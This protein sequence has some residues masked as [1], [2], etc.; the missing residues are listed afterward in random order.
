MFPLIVI[1]PAG[2]VVVMFPP[3]SA[4]PVYEMEPATVAEL[5]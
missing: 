2:T 4:V 1:L 5:D 3:I